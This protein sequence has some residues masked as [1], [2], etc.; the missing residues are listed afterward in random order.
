MG[1]WGSGPFAN[2]AAADFKLHV[3]EQIKGAFA[4]NPPD[5][6]AAAF[7]RLEGAFAT[8]QDA[9]SEDSPEA[10][11]LL[12]TYFQR[13]RAAVVILTSLMRKG[14]EWFPAEDG[15]P[16]AQWQTTMVAFMEAHGTAEQ[17]A[18]TTAVTR[19]LAR[20]VKL[21]DKPGPRRPL[22]PVGTVERLLRERRASRDICAW[23][24]AFGPDFRGAWRKC[25]KAD[26]LAALALSLDVPLDRVLR[27]GCAV[28]AAALETT[29]T[30]S[31]AG[32]LL[33]ALLRAAAQDGF[34]GVLRHAED[35]ERLREIKQELV[36]RSRLAYVQHPLA[37]FFPTAFRLV[38]GVTRKEDPAKLVVHV[39][40]GSPVFWGPP[41]RETNLRALQRNLETAELLAALA[42]RDVTR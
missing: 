20:F 23:A 6:Q 5:V 16:A 37:R 34:E 22:P 27:A 11:T 28:L 33:R 18:M 41:Q 21:A 19:E 8:F 26:W 24:H 36:G 9:L 10:Q 7:D 31:E 40:E 1:T 38:G 14:V 2:D 30:D 25:P 4:D 12:P 13:A 15:A 35:G 39:L 42:R 17:A 32:T 3:Y 29:E